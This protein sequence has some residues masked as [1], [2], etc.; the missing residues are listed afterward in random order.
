MRSSSLT[1]EALLARLQDAETAGVAAYQA[2]RALRASGL[3]RPEDFQAYDRLRAD[4]FAVQADVVSK[5]IAAVGAVEPDLVSM[6]PTPMPLPQVD[7]THAGDAPG[8]GNPAFLIAA[9]LIG[10]L[11]LAALAWLLNELVTVAASTYEAITRV[12]VRAR[13]YQDLLRARQAA[14]AA[15][16]SARGDSAACAAEARGLVETPA[17]AGLEVQDQTGQRT[18]WA[19]VILGGLALLGL[20]GLGWMVFRRVRAPRTVRGLG[21]PRRVADLDGSKSRYNLEV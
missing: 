10:L 15:C 1:F 21:A 8:L 13:Q 17:D 18:S 19:P 20:G 16:L 14:Y 5:V 9:V 4:L 12:N 7:A 2:V 11:E 3:A 6:I